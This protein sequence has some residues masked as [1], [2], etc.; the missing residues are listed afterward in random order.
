MEKILSGTSLIETLEDNGGDGEGGANSEN[1]LVVA[2]YLI[3][4]EAGFLF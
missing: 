4:R 1:V 2:F 3:S